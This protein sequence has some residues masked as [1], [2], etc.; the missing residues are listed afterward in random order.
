MKCPKCQADNPEA[1]RFCGECGTRFE[2]GERQIASP[3]WT[4]EIPAQELG[5]GALFAGR[6][7]IIDELRERFRKK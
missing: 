3:T 7:Q 5:T 1:Q 2:A 4:L 6:Y